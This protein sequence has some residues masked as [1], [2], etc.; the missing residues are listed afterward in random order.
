MLLK[1]HS[2]GV[3]FKNVFL[4]HKRKEEKQI[5]KINNCFIMLTTK[6]VFLPKVLL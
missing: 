3:F 4:R 2:L 1:D 5:D 6:R